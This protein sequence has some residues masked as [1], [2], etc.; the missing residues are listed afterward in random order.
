MNAVDVTAMENVASANQRLL[1]ELDL[2]VFVSTPA[3]LL[4]VP[5]ATWLPVVVDVNRW[6]NERVPLER[7][8][9]VVVHAPSR[10]VIK[11]TDL[12]D[13]ALVELHDAGEIDYRRVTGVPNKEL[14]AVFADA[15][16]LVDALGTGNYGVAA[17]EGMAAGCLVVSYITDQVSGFI[18]S[19]LGVELPIV[20]SAPDRLAETIRSVLGERERYQEIAAAGYE[21]VSKN[22]DGRLSAAVL[23]DFLES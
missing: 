17:C 7:R 4:E 5:G 15:D 10:E 22:H 19:S 8:V 13:N 1:G 21:F 14:P 6:S 12:V 2:P 23:K 16:I 11:R 3:L 9:P 18:Q 20:N